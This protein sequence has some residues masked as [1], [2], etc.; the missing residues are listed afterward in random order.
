MEWIPFFSIHQSSRRR[1]NKDNTKLCGR[2]VAKDMYN[3]AII[4]CNYV[5]VSPLIF[6]ERKTH[7]KEPF[8]TR[9]C[10]IDWLID[11][12]IFSLLERIGQLIEQL[13]S[14]WL[15]DWSRSDWLVD[16]LIDWLLYFFSSRSESDRWLNSC[17]VVDWLTD[18]GVIDWLI[19][20]LIDYCIFLALGANR[21]VRQ[22][23]HPGNGSHAQCI[24]IRRWCHVV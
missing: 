9:Y 7:S 19:D 2:M 6:P 10:S 3:N 15:I 20:W 8:F 21:I 4:V 17:R 18:Q 22:F 11:Y 16:W 24:G 12:C 1:I 5:S 23:R 13:S 14:G